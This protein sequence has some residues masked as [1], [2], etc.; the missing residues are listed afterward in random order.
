MSYTYLYLFFSFV[1]IVVS[2]PCRNGAECVDLVADYRCQCSAGFTGRDCETDVDE[3]SSNPCVN[4]ATCLDY[5]DSFVCRC[6][7]G[8]SG[9]RCHINDDDCTARLYSTLLRHSVTAETKQGGR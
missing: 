7:P 2:G 6:A 1:V 9:P 3:C 4:G 5:V 8:F